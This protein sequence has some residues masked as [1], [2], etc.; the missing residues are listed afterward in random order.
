MLF[1]KLRRVVW[2]FTPL[3]VLENTRVATVEIQG[4]PVT[5]NTQK[6]KV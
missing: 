5:S 1:L 4:K 6:Q 3:L 2:N